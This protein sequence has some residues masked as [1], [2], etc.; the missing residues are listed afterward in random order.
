MPISKW[1]SWARSAQQLTAPVRVRSGIV[2]GSVAKDGTHLRFL[3]IPYATVT[4]ENRFQAPGPEPSWDGVY[5]ALDGKIIC[6]QCPVLPTGGLPG[7]PIG[8]EDCL[9]INVFTPVPPA[10]KLPVMVFIH[11]GG[12]IEGSGLPL[13]YGPNYLVPKGV[14]LV[15][16]NYR[17]N[18]PG[19]LNL[20][21]KEA[22]GNAGMKDQ[23]A[24][25]RWV[26]KNISYFGG[27]Q[28]NVTIFGESA[29]GASVSYHLLSPMSR[30]LFQKAI[31]QSGSSLCP[32]AIQ[33]NP[34]Y[35]AH[36][37]A[38]AFGCDTKD[39]YELFN[40]FN[41]KPVKEL[42]TAKLPKDERTLLFSNFIYAPSVERQFDNV[43]PFL[44]EEPYQLLSNGEYT[45]VP[46]IIGTTDEEGYFFIATEKH[47]SSKITGEIEHSL[48]SNLKFPTEAEEQQIAKEIRKMYMCDEAIT[49]K[50]SSTL[51]LS[52]FYGDPFMTYPSLAE[53]ELILKSTDRPI[54]NYCFKYSGWRNMGK[55]YGGL[56]FLS[57]PGA[58][59]TDELFYLFHQPFLTWLAKI[60]RKMIDKMTTLWTNFAKHGDPTPS[61]SELV[62]QRWLPTDPADPRSFV[63]DREHATVPLWF[64]DSLKYW[65]DLYV[66]YRKT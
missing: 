60:D 10:E 52:K 57:Q 35:N 39:P 43:E 48:P 50:K 42:L 11:G 62:P 49:N 21:I 14:I 61:T 7:R 26:Q 15:T 13:V 63:L 28:D 32:W 47:F 65:R 24:A 33:S 36:L 4:P 44:T 27:D 40:F 29:G 56:H 31:T 20:G 3:G 54:Y 41:M 53:T 23:V 34:E 38:K 51:K 12:F 22:P 19:Y 5:D 59:H 6:Q 17:L 9:K 46:M 58:T 37:V 30:G 64:K 18:V 1:L 2:R 55:V 45:K 25:L 8:Q 66:K 16:F